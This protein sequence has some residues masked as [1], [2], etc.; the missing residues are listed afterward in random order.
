MGLVLLRPDPI[1][2]STRYVV[3]SGVSMEPRFHTGD[4]AI[5][6]PAS[7]YR[8]G[9]I[10]A[11]WSTLLHAVV[12]H[13]IIARDGNTYEFKG[14][15]N[16]FIDPTRPT[17]S[18]LLGRLW[19]HVPR[20][21]RLLE[22]LHTQVGAALLC[23]VVGV[24]TLFGVKESRR[25]RRR[26]REGKAGPNRLGIPIVISSRDHRP[27][28][29][30]ALFITSALTAAVL[31]V[32]G[33]IA[34]TRPA[35]RTFPV[36][37]PYTQQVQFGYSA[38]VRRGLIYPDGTINTGDPVFLTMTH[39]VAVSID[40]RLSANAPSTVTGTEEV[41]LQLTGPSGWTHNVV[42]TPSTPFRSRPHEHRGDTQCAEPGVDDRA[43]YA[44]TGGAGFAN[45]TVA[46]VP[47][48]SLKGTV[49]GQPIKTSFAPAL[50]VEI[51][52]T[53]L[54]FAGVSASASGRR[55][56]VHGPVESGY[57]QT[58]TGAVIAGTRSV[59]TR[60]AV[61]GVSP[62]ISLLRWIVLIALVPS[63]AVALYAFVR[64]RAEPFQETAHIQSRYGDMTSRSRPA[65]TS[66]GLRW[67]SRRS[68]RW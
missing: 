23:V 33:I 1:G 30:G 24:L 18:E 36:T 66:G 62:T 8:V 7:A 63:V 26:R 42:L 3:T 40:Y 20:A 56:H 28:N 17:R 27:F 29:L 32:V 60:L 59:P 54:V 65:R 48:I 39:S 31:L 38:H 68:R 9:E 43:I 22:M 55:R 52:A 16:H 37:A 47:E 45:G 44:V 46:V 6:R 25:R 19:L 11:Y 12:L 50:S 5:V 14:D 64:R 4:L 61:L 35:A 21:G 13:R 41:L 67:T 49:G 53:Q 51:G 10:V 15:N 58:E 57:S 34:F 2:G